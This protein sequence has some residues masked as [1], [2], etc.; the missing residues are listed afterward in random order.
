MKDKLTLKLEEAWRIVENSEILNNMIKEGLDATLPSASPEEAQQ[1]IPDSATDSL[2]KHLRPITDKVEEEEM[3][4]FDTIDSVEI[5]PMDIVK[6]KLPAKETIINF[7]RKK[8]FNP[9]QITQMVLTADGELDIKKALSLIRTPSKEEKEVIKKAL[10]QGNRDGVQFKFPSLGTKIAHDRELYQRLGLPGEIKKVGKKG[11]EVWEPQSVEKLQKSIHTSALLGDEKYDAVITDEGKFKKEDFIKLIS[12]R[13]EQILKQNEKIGKSG[14]SGEIY[15]DIT[16][17]AY[18]GLVYRESDGKFYLVK[19]CPNA[20]NCKSTC[21]ASKGNYVQYI[22]PWLRSIRILNF[23]INDFSG[24]KNKIAAEISEFKKGGKKVI[25]RWHDAGDFF[26]KAYL[27]L[28]LDLATEDP[29]VFHYAYTKQIRNVSAELKPNNFEFKQSFGGIEDQ[30]INPE[31]GASFIV[32]VDDE[33]FSP[34]LSKE[35]RKRIK[36]ISA[37]ENQSFAN[38]ENKKI[39]SIFKNAMF[40]VYKTTPAHIVTYEDIIANPPDS[41]RMWHVVV[42]AGNGDDA[43]KRPDVKSVL[44]MKH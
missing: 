34:L 9:E 13:P 7:L 39:F 24:F 27:K 40:K 42:K 30:F 10:A 4:G 15:Y 33:N 23:L 19:T 36:E 43:G 12:H 21:Y 25:I 41:K 28:A 18:K 5:D 20:M 8:K 2:L 16:L 35:Q 6:S 1:E 3:P 14:D 26:C 44:L 11:K 31:G 17:P 22:G 29:D 37:D 38:P 32:D